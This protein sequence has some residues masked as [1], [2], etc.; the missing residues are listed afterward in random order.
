[1]NTC[2]VEI[3]SWDL[4]KLYITQE[5]NVNMKHDIF[6]PANIYTDA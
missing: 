3:V 5:D 1:M 6:S 4:I 2:Q